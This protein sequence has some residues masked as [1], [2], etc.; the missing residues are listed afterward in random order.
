MNY[1]PAEIRREENEFITREM[2]LS[3]LR[4]DCVWPKQKQRMH[5][6]GVRAS[7]LK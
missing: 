2:N 1:K 7:A 3:V 4:H 6:P 5:S